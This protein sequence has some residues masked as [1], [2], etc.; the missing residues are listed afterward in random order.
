MRE[1]RER[2][3]LAKAI[4]QLRKR[5]LE[6]PLPE[7]V[8]DETVAKIPQCEARGTNVSEGRNSV[9]SRVG[10][11][12]RFAAAAAFILV[13]YVAGRLTR[14]D[15][16]QLREAL[17][18]SVAASLEPVLRQR[19]GEEMM[20]HWRVATSA[21]Y[22]R[23]KDELAQQY[24]DDLNRFAAQ[25]LAASNA[26]TNT[27]LAELV[28]AMD[29]AKAEDLRQI[30]LALSR[31]EAKRVQDRTQLAA[32]LQTLA[33]RTEDEFSRTKKVLARF[34]TEEPLEMSSPPRRL[35][36]TPNERSEE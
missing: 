32:G 15:I 3:V 6:A 25:T 27:L 14:P 18:P 12:L 9:V 5:G 21:A 35:P 4:A 16:E 1:K 22:V 33:Y 31:I 19:L 28:R 8:I 36:D 20:D 34:L 23:L 17:T 13:G 10:L 30:A 26:T 24:R 29:T 11:G 2:D 7:G